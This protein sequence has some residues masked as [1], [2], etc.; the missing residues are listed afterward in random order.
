MA[1]QMKNQRA[2]PKIR[3]GTGRPATKLVWTIALAALATTPAPESLADRPSVAYQDPAAAAWPDGSVALLSWGP[4]I[5]VVSIDGSAPDPWAADR[6][7]RLAPGRH[8][9]YF[10]GTV[11]AIGKCPAVTG[12]ELAEF[13]A[14]A[15]RNFSIMARHTASEADSG[16]APGC[17]IELRVADVTG[18]EPALGP[19]QR[20]A[21]AGELAHGR[22]ATELQEIKRA[23]AAGDLDAAVNLALWYLLGDD[24]LRS[25]DPVAAQAWLI[26]AAERGS[27]R[28]ESIRAELA[29][30]LSPAQR[31]AAAERAATPPLPSV[32]A[33]ET[34]R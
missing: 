10:F 14:E 1:S 2:Q 22:L 16:P 33:K 23:A 25:P 30:T 7:A 19:S 8:A 12:D 34:Q 29:P 27:R 5:S 13:A 18:P 28:A 24:P 32:A 20:L 17:H 9:I 21:R 3:S 4:E 15:G 11:R 31:K 6:R 26:A